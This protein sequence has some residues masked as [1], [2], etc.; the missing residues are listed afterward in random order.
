MSSASKANRWRNCN[1]REAKSRVS[2][3]PL[4][5]FYLLLVFGGTGV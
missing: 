4:E 2:P 1:V 5:L 3:I